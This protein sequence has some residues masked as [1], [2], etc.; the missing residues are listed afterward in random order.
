MVAAGTVPAAPLPGVR[1]YLDFR[2]FGQLA[3]G[4]GSFEQPAWLMAEMRRVASVVEAREAREAER[5]RHDGPQGK[6][7]TPRK[8]SRRPRL[9]KGL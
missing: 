4:G 8:T 5:L 7:G 9:P 2:R 3:R 1:A 6:G